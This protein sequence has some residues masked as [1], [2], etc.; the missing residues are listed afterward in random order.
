MA[1]RI[2]IVS[3]VRNESAHIER[4]VQAVVAQTVPPAR[5]VIVDDGSTD[6]TLEILS[7]LEPAAAWLHVI[8]RDPAAAA[9]TA[10]RLAVAAEARTFNAGLA[11]VDLA[12]YTHVMKLDG[13]IELPP[14][15]LEQM[16]CRF[17]EDAGL[18]LA[19]GVLRER[20][21]TGDRIIPIPPDHV[22]GALKCWT[23]ACFAAIGGVAERLGWDTIDEV[24][25]R[26]AGFRT[27]NFPEVV[28]RHHRPLASADGVMRGRARH[29]T[30]AWIVQQPPSW[31]ALRAVKLAGTRPLVL[32]G[33]AFAYGYLRAAITRTP[34]VE[35]PA[36][37]RFVHRE[38][39]TRMR[40]GGR[41]QI[42]A[43]AIRAAGAPR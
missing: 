14:D 17:A 43:P 27:R 35:D 31:A 32:S 20:A 38:L 26:M 25:A 33:A 5:W 30:C 22:H 21:G 9:G 11:T 18:G 40:R 4:V 8:A 28:S 7:R 19:G 1:A 24:Y 37:R 15:Y 41:P 42:A 34:R 36:F 3:P 29:G 10:D 13:D 16:L 39:R 23:A 2:L 6:A 12:D